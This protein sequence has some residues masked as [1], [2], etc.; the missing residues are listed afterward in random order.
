MNCKICTL[1]L[2]DLEISLNAEIHFDNCRICTICHQEGLQTDRLL[3]CVEKGIPASHLTCY[4]EKMELEIRQKPVTITQ[5]LLDW[6]NERRLIFDINSM[7]TVNANMTMAATNF[8]NSR[9]IHQL[10]HDDL[11]LVMKR[12][13][14]VAAEASIILSETKKR[15]TIKK[16]REIRDKQL[17]KEAGEGRVSEQREREVKRNR[18]TPEEKAIKAMMTIG[19]DR[20]AA[21]EELT[22]QK[23]KKLMKEH[24]DWDEA[25]ARESLESPT[26]N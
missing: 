9:W 5:E 7:L 13:E 23:I 19:L 18:Y 17:I 21:I 12:L 20:D 6:H 1:P 10:S 24:A 11:F 2:G 16:D 22:K 14:A 15:D 25:K 8:R 3:E 4:S 26:V